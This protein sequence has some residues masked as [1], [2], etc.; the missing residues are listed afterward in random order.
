MRSLDPI[1]ENGQR[2]K[3][4][5]HVLQDFLSCGCVS[6][7]VGS[8]PSN[9]RIPDSKLRNNTAQEGRDGTASPAANCSVVQLP[10]SPL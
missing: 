5:E 3:P 2:T 8:L 7:E 9:L 1:R 10:Q 6:S 4:V